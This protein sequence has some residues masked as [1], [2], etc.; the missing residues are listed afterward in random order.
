M[1][2][3]VG[4]VLW[5]TREQEVL[6]E[7]EDLLEMKERWLSFPRRAKPG[8]LERLEMVDCQEKEVIKEV[9]GCQGEEESREDSGHLDSTGVSLAETDNQGYPGL[10]G[11]QAHPE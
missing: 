1:E 2:S 7:R 6:K 3:R 4:L 8:T 10:L 5:E 9:P 11:L